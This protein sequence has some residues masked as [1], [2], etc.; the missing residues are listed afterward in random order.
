MAFNVALYASPSNVWTMTE[1]GRT[2]LVRDANCLRVGPS[3]MTWTGSGLMI[4]FDEIAPPFPPQRWMPRRVSGRIELKPRFLTGRPFDLG[5]GHQWWPI[6]PTSGISVAVDGMAPWTGDGYLDSNWG[7]SPLESEFSRWTWAR[8][9]LADGRTLVIYDALGVDG[10]WRR[11]AR[12][13]SFDGE[14]RDISLPPQMPLDNGFWGVTRS[15]HCEPEHRPHVV[16]VLEDGPFYTRSIVETVL[17]GERVTLMHESFSG[18]RF[19]SPVVKAMLP[20]RMPRR[21]RW[22]T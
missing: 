16:K 4:E 13:F 9:R 2:A 7:A 11:I 12:L 18:R 8:G 3:S 20:F 19:A 22:A 21:G 17:L 6:A 15:V 14:A 5:G 1:R 10:S